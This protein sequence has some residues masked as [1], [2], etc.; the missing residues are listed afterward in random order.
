MLQIRRNMA[1]G[2]A[3]CVSMQFDSPTGSLTQGGTLDVGIRRVPLG[4]S[5][6][7]ICGVSVVKLLELV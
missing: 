6:N 7:L 1:F 3:R 5:F 2:N 4:A